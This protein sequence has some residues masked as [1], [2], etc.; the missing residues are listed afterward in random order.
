MLGTKKKQTCFSG[1]KGNKQRRFRNEEEQTVG[2]QKLFRNEEEQIKLFQNF[3]GQKGNKPI[4]SK[5]FQDGRGRN[6]NSPKESVKQKRNS[7]KTC[8]KWQSKTWM[9]ITKNV[10]PRSMFCT[11]MVSCPV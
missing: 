1:A 10:H 7:S 3:S 11:D 2:I 5:T 6:R 8:S 4:C 9:V